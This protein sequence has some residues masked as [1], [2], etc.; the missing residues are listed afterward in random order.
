VIYR[1]PDMQGEFVTN[2]PTSLLEFSRAVGAYINLS[3]SLA[4]IDP[5][6]A[7]LCETAYS[8]SYRRAISEDGEWIA[9]AQFDS[10]EVWRIHDILRVCVA[11]QDGR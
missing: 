10:V 4:L 7:K 6:G 8:G 2:K 11:P 1:E 5:Q 3:S 9:L